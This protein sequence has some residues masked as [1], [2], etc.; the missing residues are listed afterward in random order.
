M[1]ELT[2]ETSKWRRPIPNRSTIIILASAAIIG[3]VYLLTQDNESVLYL[4]SN[5]L[6]P[7]LAFAVVVT[8]MAGLIRNGVSIKNRVSIVWLGY[9]L[10]M[11]LWLLGESTWAVYALWYSIPIP[12][13]SPADGFWLAGYVPLM[14]AMVIQAWPFG[15]FF[16]SRKM[17]ALISSVLVMAGLLLLVLVPATYA[18][19]IGNSLTGV[20]VSLAYPLFD[21]ALLVVALPI[22]FL[23]GRGTFWRPF[24]F[25]TVGLIL[26]FLGDILFSWATLNGI[27][28]DGSYLELFFHWSYLAIGYGFYLRFRT[29]VGPHMLE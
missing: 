10:G 18:S 7:L 6:P 11:L 26:A 8:A 2:Q 16:A 27:Y 19:A 22:L 1:K 28:Y 21:V 29:G 17:L 14:C 24:L 9:S 25:V 4:L 13:P 12:F 15:E 3:V 5:G 23:F 20:V